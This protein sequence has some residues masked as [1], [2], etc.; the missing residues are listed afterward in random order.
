VYSG[1]DVLDDVGWYD[2]NSAATSQVNGKQANAWGLYDMS[3]NVYE[4]AWDYYSDSYYS[5]SPG[6]DPEGAGSSFYRIFRGGAWHS[7]STSPRVSN[8]S[9]NTPDTRGNYLGFRIVR[10]VPA[11]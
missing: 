11:N 2:A 4:W 10:T 1:S 6:T 8:R 3:G 7:I 9:R 5:S